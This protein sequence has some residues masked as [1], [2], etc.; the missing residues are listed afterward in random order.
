MSTLD[1]TEQLSPTPLVRSQAGELAWL[2]SA[3]LQAGA[4][5][6][7]EHVSDRLSAGDVRYGSRWTSLGL[8]RLL[9][10]LREEAADLGAWGVLALQ[11][12][13]HQDHPECRRKRIAD[14]LHAAILAGAEAHFALE[15][16]RL[17]L[18]RQADD[19]KRRLTR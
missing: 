16:G 13:E 15:A 5:G 17:E 7:A 9:D 1:A 3:E 8:A 10:E 12:L 18:D 14:R 11:A 4:S 19:T 6:F 2:E